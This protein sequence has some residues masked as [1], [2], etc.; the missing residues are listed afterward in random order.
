M[1]LTRDI[2]S[3]YTKNK[4]HFT[5]FC[6]LQK[7]A[8]HC[9][10]HISIIASNG[11]VIFDNFG[12]DSVFFRFDQQL[13]RTQCTQES[14]IHKETDS[15]IKYVTV[16]YWLPAVTKVPPQPPIT[17]PGVRNPIQP[18]TINGPNGFILRLSNETLQTPRILA[19][20]RLQNIVATVKTLDATTVAAQFSENA[21]FASPGAKD[22]YGRQGVFDA[23]NSYYSNPGEH[24]QSL[25]PQTYYY[26]P[27]KKG[28]VMEWT[29]RAVTDG[30][31]Q[32]YVQDDAIVFRLDDNGFLSY[33]REYF[34][35][36]QTV[37][38]FA[39]PTIACLPICHNKIQI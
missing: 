33:M 15:S 32:Q 22:R 28:G 35:P 21:V 26:D 5:C 20:L 8:H 4:D 18:L 14:Q 3:F 13:I 6:C 1:P 17:P 19:Y 25:T 16:T 31:N 27:L 11:Q 2:D 24:D 10:Y 12:L 30:T 7:L 9:K 23:W 34:D 37:S 36:A 39:Q 38:F 29:W